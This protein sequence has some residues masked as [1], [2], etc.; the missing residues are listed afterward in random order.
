MY[1]KQNDLILRVYSKSSNETMKM[2]RWY[3]TEIKNMPS[4][5]KLDNLNK[6]QWQIRYNRTI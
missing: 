3:E 4:L 1:I 6:D 2:K 5:L